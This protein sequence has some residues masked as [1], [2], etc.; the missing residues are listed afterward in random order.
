MTQAQ[1]IM[2]R[3]AEKI[4]R[5]IRKQ[6]KWARRNK[7]RIPCVF[8]GISHHTMKMARKCQVD[9]KGDPYASEE[10]DLNAITEIL[11]LEDA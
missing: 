4:I 2:V 1:I 6:A 10:F 3:R 9:N 5:S 8:C 7:K 11:I